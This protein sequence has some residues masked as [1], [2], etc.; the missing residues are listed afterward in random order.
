MKKNLLFFISR[1]RTGGLV[2]CFLFPIWRGMGEENE[3]PAAVP[4][5]GKQNPAGQMLRLQQKFADL[6]LQQRAAAAA[7]TRANREQIQRLTAALQVQEENM[8]Q[9]RQA[10]ADSRKEIVGLKQQWRTQRERLIRQIEMVRL[11]LNKEQKAR[12]RDDKKIAIN[13]AAELTRITALISALP[14]PPITAP[15]K[16]PKEK[17][18]PPVSIPSGKKTAAAHLYV[19]QKGD[20]LG[21][22][23]KAFHLSVQELKQANHLQTDLIHPGQKL[24]IPGKKP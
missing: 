10:L 6:V 20:I 17:A 5:K 1:L 8:E 4:A 16:P 15:G 18:T 22:I 24:K 9:V 2:A 14:K 13:L 19:V 21:A 11:A 3:K 12:Q 23:A 7:D